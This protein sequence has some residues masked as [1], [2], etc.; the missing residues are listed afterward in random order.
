M[1]LF[2]KNHRE[3]CF[4]AFCKSPRY[5]YKKKS[6]NLFNIFSS[7]LMAVAAMFIIWQGFNPQVIFL[8]VF[9]LVSSE[10]L[11]QFRWRL[12]IVCPHCGFDPSLYLKDHERAA[13]KVKLHLEK[14]KN[15][16]ETIFKPALNIPVQRKKEVSEFE[17]SGRESAKPKGRIISKQI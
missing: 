12:N 17:A 14:R 4:C 13:E 2:Q 8:F 10:I 6:V 16:P 5:I 3:K 7:L 1:G 9:F 15:D 11:I